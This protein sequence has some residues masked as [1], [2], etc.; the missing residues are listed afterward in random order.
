MISMRSI[1]FNGKFYAGSLNG[2]HRVADR[3]I[4]QCDR[5]LGSLPGSERPNAQLLAPAH[6]AWGSSLQTIE[7][8]TVN[9]ADSQRWEQWTL[10]RT[11][12]DCVLVNLANLSPILHRRK[13]TLIHDVQFL[14]SDS[15]Y[16]WRQR[17]GYKWLVPTMATTSEIVYTVSE[18]SRQMMD[19]M[20]VCPREKSRVLHNSAEHILDSLADVSILD[21][22]QLGARPFILMFG[23]PKRYKNVEVVLQ[24]V[25]KLAEE[26]ID[27][28]V[29]GAGRDVMIAAGM[30]VPHGVIDAGKVSDAEMRALYEKAL[31]LAFPSRTE[32]FGL[33]P[34]EAMTC[35]CPVVVSAGG[36]VPEVCRD[37]ALYADVDDPDSW[38]QAF[39]ALQ[40]VELRA[41][42]IAQGKCRAA[43]F[44]WAMAGQTLMRGIL[45]LCQS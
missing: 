40:R 22:L 19:I 35:G 45:D 9:G 21:K 44:S 13:V 30:T 39:V 16:P 32:G 10:P 12:R 5:I 27:L 31:A 33:P 2:V 11:T 24:A 26:G 37:A 4:A 20:H 18:Y 38:L 6:R 41:R 42:K 43:D 7:T 23:S 3:L 34:L 36:A 17:L 14:L 15:S 25:P 29:V 8:V 1:V 28:V